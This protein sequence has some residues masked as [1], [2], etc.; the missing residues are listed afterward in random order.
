MAQYEITNIT[1]SPKAKTLRWQKA[2]RLRVAGSYVASSGRLLMNQIHDDVVVGVMA[3]LLSLTAISKS[4]RRA[5]TAD[6][7]RSEGYEIEPVNAARPRHTAAGTKASAELEYRLSSRPSETEESDKEDSP[8][9]SPEAEAPQADPATAEPE[10]DEAPTEEELA[11]AEAPEEEA[12]PS[13]EAPAEEE[14]KEEAKKT[15]PAKKTRKRTK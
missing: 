9:E 7:L 10:A 13:E 15:A 11:E 4:G 3:G 12:E 5:I 6:D 1:G 2:R 14:L 8:A